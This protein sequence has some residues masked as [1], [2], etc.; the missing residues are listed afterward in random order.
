MSA[1]GV[2]RTFSG[3]VTATAV[4]HVTSASATG[5]TVCLLPFAL[6]NRMSFPKIR[7]VRIGGVAQPEWELRRRCQSVGSAVRVGN[8][9]SKPDGYAFDCNTQH[10]PKE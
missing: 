7:S 4:Q 6:L 1:I 10:R 9:Y 8:L 3:A 5:V 2:K